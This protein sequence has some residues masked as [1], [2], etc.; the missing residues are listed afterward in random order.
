VGLAVE[1]EVVRESEEEGEVS[2]LDCCCCCC[3]CC[4]VAF[5]FW[6]PPAGE[7]DSGQMPWSLKCVI[8]AQAA[9]WRAAF[10]DEKSLSREPKG[11]GLPSIVS[12]QEKRVPEA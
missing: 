4:W 9:A 11:V 2:M 3:C 6:I 8:S 5:F 1:G 12:R 10:L 7:E